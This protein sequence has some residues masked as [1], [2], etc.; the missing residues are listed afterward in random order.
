MDRILYDHLAEMA[1]IDELVTSLVLHP[2][3]SFLRNT[4]SAEKMSGSLGL[5]PN[6]ALFIKSLED[7]FQLPEI[8]GALHDF[9]SV[10]CKAKSGTRER[11]A[12]NKMLH[13]SFSAYWDLVHSSILKKI[14]NSNITDSAKEAI[15]LTLDAFRR[16]HKY[17]FQA[18]QNAIRKAIAARG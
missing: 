15:K 13:E 14:A 18:Q 6:H 7:C 16:P 12:E 17:T 1:A 2:S 4:R 10:P 11:L 5:A 3:H 8:H 9:R